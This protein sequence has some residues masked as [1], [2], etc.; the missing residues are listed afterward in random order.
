MTSFESP[1]TH[2]NASEEKIFS[3][4]SKFSNF[5]T[6]LP[7]EITNWKS[8]EDECSFTI[9]SMISLSMQISQRVPNSYIE[10]KSKGANIFD[11]YIKTDIKKISEIQSQVKITFDADL[12]PMMAMLATKPL[13]NFVKLV[14][15]KLK[16]EMEK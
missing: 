8:T 1:N 11:F 9:Q 7:S 6:L 12:N 4:L 3:F 15:E 5:E 10:M 2:I 14:V 13:E 16:E